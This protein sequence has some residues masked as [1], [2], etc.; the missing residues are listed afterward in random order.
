METDRKGRK[1]QTGKVRRKEIVGSR[2]LRQKREKG[3]TKYRLPHKA[4]PHD[5]YKSCASYTKLFHVTITSHVPPTQS[6]DYS[7]QF[8][9][10]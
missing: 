9:N 10:P 2:K 4:I 3:C 5:N 1:S 8:W 7:G 6:N